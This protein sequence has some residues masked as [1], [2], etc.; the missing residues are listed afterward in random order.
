[1]KLTTIRINN[2]KFFAYHG[3]LEH[4]K[5]FGNQF[6]V[7]IEMHCDLSELNHTDKLSKTVNYLSVYNLVKDLFSKHKFNLIETVN[8]TICEAII[9]HYDIVKKVKVSVRKP[10]A[11]LGIIDSVE[12]INELERK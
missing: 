1:M 4:E 6:E 10:N 11:P 8:I 7:D 12:I 5:V 3:D 2:A 9:E